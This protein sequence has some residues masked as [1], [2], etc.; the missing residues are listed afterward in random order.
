MT[1]NEL[2]MRV[3]LVPRFL[4][5]V[6]LPRPPRRRSV[7]QR[8]I[9]MF[10]IRVKR[11]L[12]GKMANATRKRRVEDSVPVSMENAG[13]YIHAGR[14]YFPNGGFQNFGVGL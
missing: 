7:R 14:V 6:P 8:E 4:L 13:A 12:A 3:Y 11:N 1:N 9:E 5:S 2:I 10:A